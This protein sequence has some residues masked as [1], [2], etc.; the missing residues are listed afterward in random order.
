MLE[1]EKE[2]VVAEDSPIYKEEKPTKGEP[3]HILKKLIQT[4]D[5]LI[6]QLELIDR[7]KNRLAEMEEKLKLS[8]E[9][10]AKIRKEDDGVQR[11]DILKKK[12]I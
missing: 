11:G 8:E 7:L 10:A 6:S 5:K 3:D 12:V 9:L 4:Q 2:S 1:P